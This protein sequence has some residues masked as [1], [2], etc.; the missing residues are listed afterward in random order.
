MSGALG[1]GLGLKI[2]GGKASGAGGGSSATP[3]GTPLLYRTSSGL[4]YRGSGL[5][6]SYDV[7]DWGNPANLTRSIHVGT[8]DLHWSPTTDSQWAL[9]ILS[10]VAGRSKA[11]IQ[12]RLYSASGLLRAGIA[13][14]ANDDTPGSTDFIHLSGPWGFASSAI[15]TEIV[16]D[17]GNNLDA[18]G[19]Q[20]F[21]TTVTFSLLADG[22]TLVGWDSETG[23]DWSGTPGT[24]VS[25]QLALAIFANP[26]SVTAG[27]VNISVATDR[28]IS[29]S[30]LTAGDTIE[31]RRDDGTVED[32]GSESGGSAEADLLKTLS[33]LRA[34]RIAV[35]RGGSD[36]ALYTA[37]VGSQEAVAGGDAYAIDEDTTVLPDATVAG[38]IEPMATRHAG[39]VDRTYFGGGGQRGEVRIGAYNHATGA[40]EE[41][42]I[43]T[44]DADD[45]NVPAILVDSSGSIWA[46]Y[47]NHNTESQIYYRKSTNVEDITA[48]DAEQTLA[49]PDTAT[50]LKP[51][52]ASDGRIVVFTRTNTGTNG[53][54][55][56]RWTTDGGSTWETARE[57]AGAETWTYLA[58]R[59][60]ADL[61]TVTLVFFRHPDEATTHDIWMAQ[62]DLTT[63]AIT[64]PGSATELANLYSGAAFDPRDGLLVYDWTSANETLTQAIVNEHG[65]V[66]WVAW[67][68]ADKAGTLTHR[69]VKVDLGAGTVGTVRDIVAV[70][71]VSPDDANVQT[72]N[73]LATSEGVAILPRLVA[74]EWGIYRYVT[75][76]DGANWTSERL[77]TDPEDDSPI[78]LRPRTVRFDAD[79]DLIFYV[80]AREY[81]TTRFSGDL[82]P[83]VRP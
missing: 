30:G 9:M 53:R 10:A 63:G 29:V 49:V 83:I 28:V 13:V 17:A 61:D 36:V 57:W 70:G 69:H 18:L 66:I 59:Q 71:G 38:L 45:H 72:G 32:S 58:A 65:D 68:P 12:G 37:A 35:V 3:D 14:H 8:G 42:S 33:Y 25:G 11:W 5:D 80:R 27:A 55:A 51:F 2:G 39:S 76:D 52:H 43:A 77:D 40:V 44:L 46:F 4:L 24:H 1:L 74:G 15:I 79:E 54:W 26:A 64:E 41:T 50:Y 22:A 7:S 67:D 23:R 31:V 78:R 48:W 6:G 81:L 73:D 75:T 20:N 60:H 34:A 21:A 19:G 82:V 47:S 62:V 16:N 56:V